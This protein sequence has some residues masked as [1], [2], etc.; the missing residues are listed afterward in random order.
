MTDAFLAAYAIMPIFII[1]GG[2]I[3]I[4]VLRRN[5]RRSFHPGE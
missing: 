5:E 1:V 4:V 2:V 3:A